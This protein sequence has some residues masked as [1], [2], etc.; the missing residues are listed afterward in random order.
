MQTGV[1]QGEPGKQS[2]PSM[3]GELWPVEV[4]EPIPTK[5]G[6][7]HLDE[8]RERPEMRAPLY[9]ARGAAH[10]GVPD[11]SVEHL[12]VRVCIEGIDDEAHSVARRRRRQEQ[13]SSSDRTAPQSA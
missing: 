13:A 12:L 10:T 5:P 4:E 6:N 8:E 11:R 9:V 1:E 7:R 2:L 3:Q